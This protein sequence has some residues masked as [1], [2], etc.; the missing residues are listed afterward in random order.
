MHHKSQTE[1][2]SL[3]ILL[4]FWATVIS[5]GPPY[6]MEPLAC[7]SVTLVYCGQTVGWIKTPLGTEVGLSQGDIMLDG[8]QTPPPTERS[9]A[10]TTLPLTSIVAKRSPI[11]AS[12]ELLLQSPWGSRNTSSHPL[13][14]YKITIH[15]RSFRGA[16]IIR[17]PTHD[18]ISQ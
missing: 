7:L 8:D 14:P 2:H 15:L 9:T 18:S 13:D 3:V 17:I 16:P 5:N 6:A 4:D 1:Q 12:A 10:A 11:S